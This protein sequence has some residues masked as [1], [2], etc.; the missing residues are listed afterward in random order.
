VATASGVVGEVVGAQGLVG[1]VEATTPITSSSSTDV[2]EEVGGQGGVVGGM[3]ATMEVA[4]VGGR[5]E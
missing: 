4:A 2:G 1:E 3:V 5:H